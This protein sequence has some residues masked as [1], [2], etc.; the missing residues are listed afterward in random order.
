MAL[1][2]G[3]RAHGAEF[4]ETAAFTGLARRSPMADRK[5]GETARA[6]PQEDGVAKITGRDSADLGA[7]IEPLVERVGYL[8]AGG[9]DRAPFGLVQL[10]IARPV[11]CRAAGQRRRRHDRGQKPGGKAEFL[12]E[13]QMQG[14]VGEGK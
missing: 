13:R 3:P 5:S 10:G 2:R 12:V 1:G 14:A 8:A 7:Q 6:V 11:Y 9:L 4:D